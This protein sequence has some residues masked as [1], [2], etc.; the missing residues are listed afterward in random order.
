[1]IESTDL[2]STAFPSLID[3][4]LFLAEL[5]RLEGEPL[6]SPIARPVARPRPA[7]PAADARVAFEPV[8]P[9]DVNRWNLHPPPGVDPEPA[10][11]DRAS[12]VPAILAIAGGLC[13]GAA[14]AAVVFHDRLVQIVELFAR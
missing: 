11:R 12:R 14:G 2:S 4:A 10:V 6:A 7:E 9:R 8:I 1:M 3:D 5:D 13:A